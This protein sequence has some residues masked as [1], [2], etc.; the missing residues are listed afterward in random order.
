MD[1]VAVSNCG[2]MRNDQLAS[3]C[4]SS[5]MSA[6]IS[7]SR[8]YTFPVSLTTRASVMSLAAMSCASSVGFA[9]RSL[10]TSSH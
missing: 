5:W 6:S 8:F 10:A 2:V 3:N 7:R 1:G 4:M 9:M